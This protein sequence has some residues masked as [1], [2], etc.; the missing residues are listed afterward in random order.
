METV[1]SYQTLVDLYEP[2]DTRRKQ[3]SNLCEKN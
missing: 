2:I 1:I 3:I